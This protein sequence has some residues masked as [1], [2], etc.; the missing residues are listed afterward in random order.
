M[1]ADVFQSPALPLV[2]ELAQ[3]GFAL[4]VTGDGRVRVEPGSRLTADQRQLL[5]QHKAAVATVLRGCDPEVAV[6]R[7]VFRA[8]IEA[9]E[10][11]MLPALVYKPDIAYTAGVCFSCGDPN[12]RAAHGRCWRC[13]LAWRL[14]C[15]L[16]I[17]S[18]LAAVVD[19][20][21]QVA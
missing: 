5:V 10:R 9:A 17:S 18:E 2:L 3:Q 8:Q 11:V 6:R 15:R 12:G 19:G 14:A 13:S 7:D 1:V 20:A 4:V 21:R 16:P